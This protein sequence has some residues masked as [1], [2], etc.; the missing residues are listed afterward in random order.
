[1]LRWLAP[2]GH[3]LFATLGSDSFAEWRRAHETEGLVPGTP[4]FPSVADLTA[5]LPDSQ[6]GP[7]SADRL[8]ETHGSALDFMRSLRAIGASTAA[9]RHRPLDSA[10]MRRVMRNFENDGAAVTYEVV[11]CHYGRG[12]HHP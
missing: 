6:C 12:Q 11:T 10:A 4:A 7:H 5:M 1:M 3:C 8:V 9:Y 2:G